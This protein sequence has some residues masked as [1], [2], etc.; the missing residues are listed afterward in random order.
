MSNILQGKLTISRLSPGNEISIKL[1]DVL[2]SAQ[3]VEIR[4]T[5][6][7]FALALTGLGYV[8]C[9][10]EMTSTHVG[11]ER[12]YKR[13]WIFVDENFRFGRMTNEQAQSL[14]ERYEIDG[15]KARLSDF[16]NSHNLDMEG[17][18][19][20]SFTRYIDPATGQPVT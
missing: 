3:A 11:K 18:Y 6:E 10:F 9:T 1:Q 14:V 2:S 4:I 19:S 15:W 5:P 13:Q 7:Q 17:N 12:Q 20:V 8:D 16:M